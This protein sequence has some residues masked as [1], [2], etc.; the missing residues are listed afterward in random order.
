MFSPLAMIRRARAGR[1]LT[2]DDG[3]GNNSSS[4]RNW[5]AFDTAGTMSQIYAS[6]AGRASAASTSTSSM[7]Q[8]HQ[9][10]QQHSQ[11]DS[12]SSKDAAV[13]FALNR[14]A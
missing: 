10:H 13:S 3:A 2:D 14:D 1:I 6:L 7:E 11:Q 5:A 12:S 4:K 8:Q 9:H